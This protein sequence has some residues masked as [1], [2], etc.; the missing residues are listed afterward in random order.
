MN[1]NDVIKQNEDYRIRETEIK[2][3][4]PSIEILDFLR[5]QRTTGELRIS[6][7]QGGVRHVML[8]EK[9]KI[10]ETE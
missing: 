4:V 5:I 1:Q 8:I 10:A 9:T 3:N 2:S 7:F 6:L